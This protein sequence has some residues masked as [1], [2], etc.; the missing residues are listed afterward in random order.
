MNADIEGVLT[1]VEADLRFWKRM[2]EDLAHLFQE[3]FPPKSGAKY[4]WTLVVRKCAA[5]KNC[6][7]CPHSIVWRR[8]FKPKGRRRD[9]WTST[10]ENGK[11]AI[12]RHLPKELRVTAEIREMFL[13]F[14]SLRKA[15]M[16]EHGE[17]ARIRMRLLALNRE[18]EK[19]VRPISKTG[20]FNIMRDL[21]R[22]DEAVK[23]GIDDRVWKLR[24]K[25]PV[26]L[27]N[28]REVRERRN[29]RLL[30]GETS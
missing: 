20:L 17:L 15:I 3:Q 12:E 11:E 13:E 2:M 4:F 1:G 9:Y 21:L 28:R 27:K 7:M 24:V 26:I 5:S 16:Q 18:A 22:T 14:E 29:R 10:A 30:E 6:H 25:V 19:K 23:S 8:Y